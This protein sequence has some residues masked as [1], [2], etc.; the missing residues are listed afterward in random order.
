MT[1]KTPRHNTTAAEAQSHGCCRQ[2]SLNHQRPRAAGGPGYA[3]PGGPVSEAEPAAASQ[4]W[5]NTT[6]QISC[7]HQ[8]KFIIIME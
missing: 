4:L 1:L 7:D 3:G 5:M 6:S 8:R 2:H